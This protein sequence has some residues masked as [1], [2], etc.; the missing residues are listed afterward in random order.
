MNL[1][2]YSQ[3]LMWNM[4]GI[5]LVLMMRRRRLRLKACFVW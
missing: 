5:S 4:A 3:L 1:T 2:Y